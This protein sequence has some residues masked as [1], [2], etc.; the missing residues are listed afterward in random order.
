MKKM[1][2][3]VFSVIVPLI[4]A[5]QMQLTETNC[6]NGIDDDGDGLIDCI[7]PDCLGNPACGTPN[8]GPVLNG[9]IEGT[10]SSPE[11]DT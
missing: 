11:F 8:N 2:F 1:F 5:A 6:S 9:V 7:D 3:L 10:G 4:M